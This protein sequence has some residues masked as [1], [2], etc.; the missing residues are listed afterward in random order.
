MTLIN[1]HHGIVA[2]V[3]GN[4]VTIELKRGGKF[5]VDANRKYVVGEKV[6]FVLNQIENKVVEVMPKVEADELVSVASEEHGH[7]VLMDDY[8]LN[9]EDED[10]CDYVELESIEDYANLFDEEEATFYENYFTS[11]G[12]DSPRTFDFECGES[13][14]NVID[15][16]DYFGDTDSMEVPNGSKN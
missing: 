9:L 8:D 1:Q 15:P 14:R 16:A 12:Q 11:E 7:G 2:Q 3:Q 5:T 13:G 6:C 4:K 10:D